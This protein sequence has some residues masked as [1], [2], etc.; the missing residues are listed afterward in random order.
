MRLFLG[1]FDRRSR[2]RQV[3]DLGRRLPASRPPAATAAV[4]AG[5]GERDVEGFV[6]GGLG[7]V[8][9]DLLRAVRGIAGRRAARRAHRRWRR[10]NAVAPPPLR[11]RARG[12]LPRNCGRGHRAGSRPVR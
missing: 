7:F 8:S 6:G 9:H 3:D 12:W 4:G 11:R 10:G 1:G 2:L 5:G